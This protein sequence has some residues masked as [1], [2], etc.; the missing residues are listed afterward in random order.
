M[1][2]VLNPRKKQ[3]ESDALVTRPLLVNDVEG[4]RPL[5]GN[6]ENIKSSIQ[7]STIS[8]M[9]LYVNLNNIQGDTFGNPGVPFDK[10][11]LQCLGYFFTE[12]YQNRIQ[13]NIYTLQ[14]AKG[15]LDNCNLSPYTPLKT[16]PGDVIE[17]RDAM[18]FNHVYC[19]IQLAYYLNELDLENHQFFTYS[20]HFITTGFKLPESEYKHDLNYLNKK[21]KDYSTATEKGFKITSKSIIKNHFFGCLWI[22]CNE[23]GLS[24]KNFNDKKQDGRQYSPSVKV[25][26]EFR[27]YFPLLLREY[28][29][30][31]AFASFVDMLLNTDLKDKV[32]LNVMGAFNCDRDGAKIIYNSML[33]KGKYKSL[34]ELET[35]FRRIGYGESSIELSK[36]VKDPIN[37]FWREM[38]LQ[39]QYAIDNFIVSNKI[40]RG[41]RLHDAI[42]FIDDKFINQKIKKEFTNYNFECKEINK[43]ENPDF[44]NLDFGFKKVL[45]RKS[46]RTSIPFDFYEKYGGVSKEFIN[47]G[48][49]NIFNDFRIYK[50]DFSVISCSF[51]IMND[52]IN[53]LQFIEKLRLSFLSCKALNFDVNYRALFDVILNNVIE[54]GLYF[55]N[56]KY[57]DQLIEVWNL[58][59][60]EDESVYN[61]LI[62]YRNFEY[63]GDD[64]FLNFE[65]VTELK[66]AQLLSKTYYK[67]I[68]IDAFIDSN[69]K[70][71]LTFQSLGLKKK[72]ENTFITE[73]ID[74]INYYNVNCTNYRTFQAKKIEMSNSIIVLNRVGYLN[75][76]S[77]NDLKKEI[78]EII[79]NPY[80]LEIKNKDPKLK[81]RNQI[82]VNLL[83]K[84]KDNFE[85]SKELLCISP[86][87]AFGISIQEI[88]K[89]KIFSIPPCFIN[90]N[91]ISNLQNWLINIKDNSPLTMDKQQLSLNPNEVISWFMFNND[92]R[93]NLRDLIFYKR[94]IIQRQE[95]DFERLRFLNLGLKKYQVNFK[96]FDDNELNDVDECILK[97]SLESISKFILTMV[98]EEYKGKKSSE[99]FKREFYKYRA[100]VRI[101]S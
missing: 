55:F 67:L 1:S 35:F 29:L 41:S 70:E 59:H 46:Y 54:N 90:D 40:K 73:L 97:S 6:S 96:D 4:T 10:L 82:F 89:G 101:A 62:K 78:K 68:E 42:F 95:S 52:R 39:E 30:K 69:K 60:L 81:I 19:I 2:K 47:R 74:E 12:I 9:D 32:Y 15:C 44:I 64:V 92:F 37:P 22:I 49:S 16:I 87:D 51:N 38:Q 45:D 8:E 77:Y 79:K 63:I 98:K 18:L 84:A 20:H 85:S 80:L 34:E 76:E 48:E 88:A 31:S 21:Y 14:F 56:R 61:S 33:N 26:R 25:A 93:D 43:I 83:L 71:F 28:D 94:E 11:L 17:L 65:F 36:M 3:R 7:N 99:E 100:N 23:L 27:Q 91:N 66:K 13:D 24:T 86:S 53:D 72:G 5:F 57:I 75:C 58:E 50:N